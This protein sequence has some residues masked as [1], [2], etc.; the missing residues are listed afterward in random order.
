MSARE[1]DDLWMI[2]DPAWGFH[3]PAYVAEN[4]R[5]SYG[6]RLVKGMANSRVGVDGVCRST[7]TEMGEALAA[8]IQEVRGFVRELLDEGLVSL[9]GDTDLETA[10]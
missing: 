3:V 4:S 1:G 10:T 8:D 2:M 5:L 9:E 7:L 6:A